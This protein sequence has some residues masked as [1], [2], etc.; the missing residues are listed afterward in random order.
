MS[1]HSGKKAV[2]IAA[3]A[4]FFMVNA[5]PTVNASILGD[6]LKVERHWLSGRQIRG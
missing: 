3:M 2:V 4:S 5:V 1:F 6:V